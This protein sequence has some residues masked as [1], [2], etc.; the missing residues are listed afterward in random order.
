M[1]WKLTSGLPRMS[2]LVLMPVPA[3][4]AWDSATT[5]SSRSFCFSLL[6]VGSY[7]KVVS[8]SSYFHIILSFF[9]GILCP[10]FFYKRTVSCSM[11]I[12]RVE[13]KE[14]SSFAALP[15]ALDS[16]LV[17]KFNLL[18]F[19]SGSGWYVGLSWKEDFCTTITN[20]FSGPSTSW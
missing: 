9:F 16:N 18:N 10:L 17:V 4:E 14:S 5:T 13:W 15:S 6:F 11:T 20:L 3:M 1:V 19:V 2:S 7:T 8:V 12:H